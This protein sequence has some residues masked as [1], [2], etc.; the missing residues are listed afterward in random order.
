M[1]VP[2][3]SVQMCDDITDSSHLLYQMRQLRSIRRSLSA[4]AMHALV[5]C[6]LDYCN[7]LLTGAAD[8]HFKRLQSV[9]NT[10]AK[11]AK[12]NKTVEQNKSPKLS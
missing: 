11:M 2:V 8:V 12:L 4:D 7:S 1:T 3:T 10:A 9:Q 6:R 5:H